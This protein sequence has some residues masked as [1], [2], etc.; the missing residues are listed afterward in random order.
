MHIRLTQDDLCKKNPDRS[1]HGLRPLL[2]HS[3]LKLEFTNLAP[4]CKLV[5]VEG[6]AE[7]ENAEGRKLGNYLIQEDRWISG[8]P[9]YQLVDSHRQ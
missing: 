6:D 2:R 1:N 9:V 8:R 4:P 3:A 7:V 5:H